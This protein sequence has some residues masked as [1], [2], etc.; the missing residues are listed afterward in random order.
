MTKI[1]DS[2]GQWLSQYD[3]SYWITFT[4]RYTLTLP[5]GRRLMERFWNHTDFK[6]TGNARLF[7][8]AEPFDLREGYHLHGLLKCNGIITIKMIAQI[9]NYACGNVDL[10]KEDWHRIQVQ[11]YDSKLGAGHYV[12][13]YITKRLADYDILER[14]A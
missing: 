1:Q 8:C 4:T 7:W 12:A 11:R 14:I 13:K 3:W 2:Y 6:R 9:H 10:R 5:S